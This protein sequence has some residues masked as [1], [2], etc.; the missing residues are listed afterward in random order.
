MSPSL[1]PVMSQPLNEMASVY[2][3]KKKGLLIVYIM[4]ILMFLKFD[5]S[6]RA[7]SKLWK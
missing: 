6:M 1:I 2:Y 4:W 5:L 7:V 3:L